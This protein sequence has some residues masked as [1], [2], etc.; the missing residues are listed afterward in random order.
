MFVAVT[1]HACARARARCPALAAVPRR[2]LRDRI[3]R[4]VLDALDA[5][6]ASRL[7][8]EQ[9]AVDERD[10]RRGPGDETYVWTAG[11]DRFYV[12]V[13]DRGAWL[14]VTTLAPTGFAA[15]AA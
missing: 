9:A 7:K 8:P 4:D 10:F 2:Q 1:H 12:L 14:V 5:G 15:D 3:R 6:R 11:R 13:L